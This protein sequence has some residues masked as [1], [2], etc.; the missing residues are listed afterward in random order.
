M[1]KSGKARVFWQRVPALHF[2]SI[3]TADAMGRERARATVGDPTEETLPMNSATPAIQ[4][5]ARRLISFETAR[6]SSNGQ[7][8][9][10]VQAWEKLRLPL[11]KLAGVAGFRSLMTRG[12]AWRRRKCP[13]STRCKSAPTGGRRVRRGQPAAKVRPRPARRK[14]FS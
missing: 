2:E 8:R 6:D 11:A 4:K 5:L 1:I 14:S 9:E 12:L 10:A 7:V 3:D 13:G